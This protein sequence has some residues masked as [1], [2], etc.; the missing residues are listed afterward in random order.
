VKVRLELKQEKIYVVPSFHYMLPLPH[1]KI[2]C[3]TSFNYDSLRYT[4]YVF[5]WNVNASMRA[6]SA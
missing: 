6:Y 2:N 5:P 1:L 3:C 4:S